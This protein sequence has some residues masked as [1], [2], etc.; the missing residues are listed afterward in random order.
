[1][2]PVNETGTREVCNRQRK[3]TKE[4]IYPVRQRERAVALGSN[5]LDKRGTEGPDLLL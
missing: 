1:M 2:K 4:Y 3:I 5:T